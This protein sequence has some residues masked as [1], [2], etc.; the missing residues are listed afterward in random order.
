MN[1]EQSPAA[2]SFRAVA[3]VVTLVTI[4][5]FS[6]VAYSAYQDVRGVIGAAAGTT[7]GPLGA[8]QTTVNGN[9]E[10]LAVNFTMPNNGLYPLRLTIDCAP[11]SGSP[12]ACKGVDVTIQPGQAQK[13]TLLVTVSDLAQLQNL[14]SRGAVPHLQANMSASLEPFATLGVSFDLG[15]MLAGGGQ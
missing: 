4:V 2:R 13:V 8:V 12:M 10:T 5:T 3:L 9:Q 7:R 1:R 14:L 11:P 15:S 6:T